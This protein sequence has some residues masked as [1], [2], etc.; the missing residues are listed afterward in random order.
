MLPGLTDASNE[1][2]E[3]KKKFCG[4][5]LPKALHGQDDI[6][7]PHEEVDAQST[8]PCARVNGSTQVRTQGC[9]STGPC[10]L[11]LSG[12]P[13]RGGPTERAH[14]PRRSALGLGRYDAHNKSVSCGVH[15]LRAGHSLEREWVSQ[16]RDPG[17]QSAGLELALGHLPSQSK[18]QDMPYPHTGV[19]SEDCDQAITGSMGFRWE[20]SPK[21]PN[22]GLRPLRS[23]GSGTF[24]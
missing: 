16:G 10:G 8:E 14:R 20:N 13:P 12:H 21:G 23:P 6:L 7:I 19:P 11:H 4:T 2:R 5:T 3:V 9:V 17:P 15:L 18:L 22:N 24:I 1:T